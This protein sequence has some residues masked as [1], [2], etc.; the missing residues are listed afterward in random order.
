MSW[1]D[2]PISDVSSKQIKNQTLS[3]QTRQYYLDQSCV[4]HNPPSALKRQKHAQ[5][6]EQVMVSAVG[7]LTDEN[8]MGMYMLNQGRCHIP[9]HKT[10]LV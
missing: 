9:Q 6:S 2:I 3:A 10:I 8:G 5:G 4:W 7:R 1:Q